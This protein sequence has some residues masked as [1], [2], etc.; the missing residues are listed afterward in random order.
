MTILLLITFLQR[1]M[2]FLLPCSLDMTVDEINKSTHVVSLLMLSSSVFHALIFRYFDPRDA[3]QRV[4]SVATGRIPQRGLEP[5]IEQILSLTN[6]NGNRNHSSQPTIRTQDSVLKL[7]QVR[8]E[9]NVVYTRV[10]SILHF[11]SETTGQK[12]VFRLYLDKIPCSQE[13]YKWSRQHTI[14][15]VPVSM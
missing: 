10:L 13:R 7:I 2:I 11:R 9:G 14:D 4:N 12:L 1:E 5:N 15:Y 8:Q 6:S 3:L